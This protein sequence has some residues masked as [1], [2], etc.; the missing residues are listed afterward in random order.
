MF[1]CFF[2]KIEC[3][4]QLSVAEAQSLTVAHRCSESWKSGLQLQFSGDIGEQ[5]ERVY[6]C[7]YMR[8]RAIAISNYGRKS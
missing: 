3:T 2:V 5:T 7:V 6:V 4:Y 1:L 8:V